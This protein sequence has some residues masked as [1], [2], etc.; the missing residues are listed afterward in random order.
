MKIK[1]HKQIV[2]MLDDEWDL[3]KKRPNAIGKI[4]AWIYWFEILTDV[5]KIIIEKQDNKVVG[6]CGYSK[7]NSK[8]RYFR[9]KFYKILKNILIYSPFVKNRQ[10]IKEYN[11]AYEYL[12]KNL[13]HYFDGEV[14]ILIVDKKYRGN[15]IGEKLL[16]NIFD[17]AYKDNM[18]NIQ[19]STDE[20]C[21]YKFYEKMNCKKVYE[22][23]VVNGEPNEDTDKFIEKG[24]IYERKLTQ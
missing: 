9:K 11:K 13:E 15:K 18:K 14:A 7:W 10:A 22:T 6:V 21:N 12:P 5:E 3:G 19:I 23:D 1:Y 24:F 16:T 8:K 4:C 17:L 20:S 2:D